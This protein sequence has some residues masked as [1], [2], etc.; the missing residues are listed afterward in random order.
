M[1][2]VDPNKSRMRA[3]LGAVLELAPS[4]KGFTL[5]EFASQVRAIT[6]QN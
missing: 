5:S 2:G 6:G 1:G 3:A 4:P